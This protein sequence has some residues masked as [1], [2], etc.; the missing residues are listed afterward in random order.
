MYFTNLHVL[1][2]FLSSGYPFFIFLFSAS[3]KKERA[4]RSVGFSTHK[5]AQKRNWKVAFRCVSESIKR[6][7]A[8]RTRQ[9]RPDSSIIKLPSQLSITQRG[10]RRPQSSRR[11]AVHAHTSAHAIVLCEQHGKK[12]VRHQTSGKFPRF[13]TN[14]QS[15]WTHGLWFCSRSHKNQILWME[16]LWTQT[17]ICGASLSYIILTN[18]THNHTDKHTL[19]QMWQHRDKSFPSQFSLLSHKFHVC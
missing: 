9:S 15:N 12:P 16:E 11:Q 10:S 7:T 8:G 13:V 17:N 6:A 2:H 3:K 1:T 19:C 18:S 14:L 5:S 4:D